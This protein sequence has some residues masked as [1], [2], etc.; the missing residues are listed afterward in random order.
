[1][2]IGVD[3]L[4]FEKIWNRLGFQCIKEIQNLDDLLNFPAQISYF[5]HC[6]EKSME[7]SHKLFSTVSHFVH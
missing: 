7:I 2:L 5:W 6:L 4:F 3:K 1:M